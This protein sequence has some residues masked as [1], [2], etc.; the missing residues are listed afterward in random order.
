MNFD[1]FKLPRHPGNDLPEKKILAIAKKYCTIPSDKRF[2]YPAVPEPLETLGK[3]DD[4]TATVVQLLHKHKQ[5]KGARSAQQKPL[6]VL[7]KK[8]KLGRPK[9]ARAANPNA[10]SLLTLFK[11]TAQGIAP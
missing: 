3:R 9:K 4:K 6:K 7:T 2:Y 10:P 5:H 11:F 1:N 8:K